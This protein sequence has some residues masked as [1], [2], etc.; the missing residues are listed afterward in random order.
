MSFPPFSTLIRN[1]AHIPFSS[2]YLGNFFIPTTAGSWAEIAPLTVAGPAAN[3][4]TLAAKSAQLALPPQRRSL[5]A[6]LPPQQAS[7]AA[8]LI[9]A[10]YPSLPVADA[11]K[12]IFFATQSPALP[13]EEDLALGLVSYHTAIT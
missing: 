8:Q 13:F 9:Q 2:G 5:A 1:V 10:R 7:E 6:L 11:A 4:S 3:V 12:L